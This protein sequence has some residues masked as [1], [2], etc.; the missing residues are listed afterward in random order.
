[1]NVC[2]CNAFH[3]C[4]WMFFFYFGL[5][6]SFGCCCCNSN[7]NNNNR[8][9]CHEKNV[10]WFSP[11]Y[12][13]QTVEMKR[14]DVIHNKLLS[15]VYSDL[16]LMRPFML[17][18]CLRTHTHTHTHR[19]KFVI[20]NFFLLFFFLFVCVYL[21][22]KCNQRIQR[23][24]KKNIGIDLNALAKCQRPQSNRRHQL[25]YSFVM[26]GTNMF[27]YLNCGFTVR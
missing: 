5:S 19:V 23:N 17:N 14:C 13:K 7:N 10:I 4:L 8:S 26:R 1:M 25:F 2:A 20:K 9:V 27:A 16:W 12:H 22:K 3:L 11:K 15:K 18:I 21:G 6:S 24:G